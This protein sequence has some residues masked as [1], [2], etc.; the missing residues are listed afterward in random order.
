VTS[1]GLESY[2][3]DFRCEDVFK[4]RVALEA[5][6]KLGPSAQLEPFVLTGLADSS[7]YVKRTACD[8]AGRW[9]LASA[10]SAI[11]KLLHDPEEDTVV[12]A[13]RALETVSSADEIPSLL[14]VFDRAKQKSVRHAAAWTLYRLVTHDTWL[15]LFDRFASDGLARHRVWA[16]DLAQ[17]FGANEVI[18]QLAILESDRD[19]HVRAATRRALGQQEE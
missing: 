12:A 4:R 13:L 19:G 7:G 6:G 17:R 9:P 18:T 3:R 10:R 5:I 8:V 11:L 16:S 15:E 14:M 2:L 1:S